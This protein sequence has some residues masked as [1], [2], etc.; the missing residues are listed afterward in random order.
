MINIEYI[1]SSH[2]DHRCLISDNPI[3]HQDCVLDFNGFL[4]AIDCDKCDPFNTGGKKKPDLLVLRENNNQH[5]WFVIEIKK[6]L[7]EKAWDQVQSGLNIL[8]NNANL[9]GDKS[10]YR[11]RALL[12]FTYKNRVADI[13]RYRQPFKLN[14]RTVPPRIQKCGEGRI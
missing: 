11:P 5:E 4:I 14:G 7:R 1:R 10:A 12:A 8:S 13:G 6:Q 3:D 9:F 2:H